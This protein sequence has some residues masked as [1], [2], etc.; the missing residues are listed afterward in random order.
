MASAPSRAFLAPRNDPKSRFKESL[1][2]RDAETNTRDA[3]A[4]R[5]GRRQRPRLQL[6]RAFFEGS[7]FAAQVRE[8]FASEMERSGEENGMRSLMRLIERV[9]DRWSDGAV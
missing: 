8:R 7:G 9:S 4:T 3:C 5:E 1:F 6:L 2:Q